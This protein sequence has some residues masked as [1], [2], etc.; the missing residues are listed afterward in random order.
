MKIPT[1]MMAG[2]LAFGAAP[3]MTAQAETKTAATVE[4]R[5]AEAGQYVSDSAVTAKVKS[6]MLAE[7]GLKATAINV[8]TSN[9]TVQLSGFVNSE[10]QIAQAETVARH[11]KGVKEV[12][13]DL[14]L[15][16]ATE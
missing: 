12:K 4:A 15:K 3:L 10:A 6:A 16:S 9:G 7:K 14:R 2:A 8:E 5:T 1:L 11:V 13:N